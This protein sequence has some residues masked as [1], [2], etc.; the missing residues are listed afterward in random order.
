MARFQVADGGNGLQI[1]MVNINILNKQWRTAEYGRLFNFEVWWGLT[2]PRH[3]KPACYMGPCICG[4]FEHGNE[5]LGS[6]EG[7]EFRD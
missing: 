4:F 7:G 1:Y 5:L 2:T 6:I 3:K